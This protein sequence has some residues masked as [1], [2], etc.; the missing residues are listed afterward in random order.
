MSET[1]GKLVLSRENA[2]KVLNSTRGTWSRREPQEE[3]GL[4]YDYT[5]L[6][7]PDGTMF[8]LDQNDEAEVARF[9]E[10]AEQLMYSF[11]VEARNNGAGVIYLRKYVPYWLS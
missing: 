7:N 1:G 2:P 3:D 5:T 6:K 9:E 10:F 4:A 8:F 11:G